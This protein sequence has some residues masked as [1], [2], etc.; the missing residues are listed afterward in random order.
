MNVKFSLSKGKVMVASLAGK[1]QILRAL[2]SH[3]SDASHAYERAADRLDLSSAAR[4]VLDR[5]LADD[6]RHFHWI[7]AAESGS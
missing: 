7:E 5:A 2:K 4:Q 3:E 6:R 1:A